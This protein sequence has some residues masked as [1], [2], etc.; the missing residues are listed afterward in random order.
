MTE[1]IPVQKPVGSRTATGFAIEIGVTL[2]LLAFVTYYLMSIQGLR[3]QARLFPTYVLLAC[4]V[5]LVM[6]FVS[7]VARF[8]RSRKTVAIEMSQTEAGETLRPVWTSLLVPVVLIAAAFGINYLG[9][10][11]ALPIV[12]A[13]LFWLAGCR[14]WWLSPVLA[15]PTT[16]LVWLIFDQL[17]GVSLP[18]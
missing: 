11:V 7:A 18:Y 13:V 14:P 8:I 5:L 6:V 12:A 4:G 2:G 16:A 1:G 3:P 17:V 9:F 10:Y 15:V